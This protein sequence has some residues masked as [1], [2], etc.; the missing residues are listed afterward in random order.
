MNTLRKHLTRS[1]KHTTRQQ[2][3]HHHMPTHRATPD[4]HTPPPL[5]LS[6]R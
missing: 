4:V 2:T 6:L 1:R 3:I 5:T